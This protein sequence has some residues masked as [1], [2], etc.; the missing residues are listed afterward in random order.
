MRYLHGAAGAVT[1]EGA[2]RKKA[3]T[4]TSIPILKSMLKHIWPKDRRDLKI[5][6]VAAVC[7]LVAAK[8]GA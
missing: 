5:R 6:V 1:E 7:L 3:I 8:V 2:K 4:A